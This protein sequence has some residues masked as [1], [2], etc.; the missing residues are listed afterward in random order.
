MDIAQSAQKAAVD[1]LR[2]RALLTEAPLFARQFSNQ[3]PELGERQL[4]VVVLI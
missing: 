2:L 3:L 1:R 4:P